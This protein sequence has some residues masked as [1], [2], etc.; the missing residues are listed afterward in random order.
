MRPVNI[1]GELHGAKR[2]GRVLPR[3][4]GAQKV[5]SIEQGGRR[6]APPPGRG[7][8]S[9]AP[10][11]KFFLISLFSLR[12]M[13]KNTAPISIENTENSRKRLQFHWNLTAIEWEFNPSLIGI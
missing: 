6:S 9:S 10:Q 11:G 8:K 5:W 2:S 4:R 7:A 3:G 1:F 13:M 12:K